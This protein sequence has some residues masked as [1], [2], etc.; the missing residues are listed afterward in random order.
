MLQVPDCPIFETPEEGPCNVA[1]YES[2][3]EKLVSDGLVD[4]N[5]VGITGFSRTCFDVLEALTT[6]NIRF[7]A[8]SITNGFTMGYMEYLL[9]VDYGNNFDA[10]TVEGAL[11]VPPPFGEGL[12]QWIARSPVFKMDKVG[13][14][15]QIVATS[16][17]SLLEMWEPYAALRFMHRPVDL[18]IL[19]QGTHPLT[20]PGQLMLSQGGVVDW[21]RFWLQDY[22]DPDPSKTEE[23]AR[24]RELRKQDEQNHNQ[25]GPSSH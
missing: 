23:Y 8:A 1:G 12:T 21:F 10:H 17:S 16:H 2:G 20:N 3:V 14:P 25:L 13:A 24:W 15:M 19:G 9:N 18:M 11:G 6:S 22:Q 4:A 5:R 7:E